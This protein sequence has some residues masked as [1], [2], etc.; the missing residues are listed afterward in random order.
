MGGGRP[1][2]WTHGAVSCLL[3]VPYYLGRT[4]ARTILDNKN[5]SADNLRLDPDASPSARA[6]ER[7]RGSLRH[8]SKRR[9]KGNGTPP[10]AMSTTATPPE[11]RGRPR[12][13]LR[14]GERVRDYQT[15]TL[16]L[17][18]DTRAL[19][20]SLCLQ[21]DLPLWQTVRH[22]T[23]CFVRDLPGGERRTV[24]RRAKSW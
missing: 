1:K 23:V 24:V 20:K 4:I 13:G 19:L 22:L 8:M 18:D 5:C 17:P 16:R 6:Y 12:S 11:R 15:V 10:A 2:V 21:M 3:C 7:G 14:P 9:P